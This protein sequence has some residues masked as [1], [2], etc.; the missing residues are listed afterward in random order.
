MTVKCRVCG[1]ELAN[2]WIGP[3]MKCGSLDI[4]VADDP[5]RE[6]WDQYP[7]NPYVAT[8]TSGSA[9]I[10]SDFVV[11]KYPQTWIQFKAWSDEEKKISEPL[12]K[13]DERV[14]ILYSAETERFMEKVAE[15]VA[16][17][18]NHYVMT[19]SFIFEKGTGKRI[20]FQPRP[21]E[22][23][24]QYLKRMIDDS[25]YAIILYSEQGGQIIETSWCS[26]FSKPTLGLV[27]FYRGHRKPQ[28]KERCCD[29][30]KDHGELFE[31]VCKK[32]NNYKDKTGGFICSD[33]SVFCHFTQQK[34]TKMIFDFYIT[35]P[36]MFLIGAE[37][38]KHF[39][40][41]IDNFLLG[42]MKK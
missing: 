23:L 3:C 16:A 21:K 13:K 32:E 1:Q 24:N 25:K 2:G 40:P 15:Y 34:I 39:W 37:D 41:Q 4:S 19:S 42:N 36:G 12:G 9:T 6:K 29:F 10:S 26:D 5:Y 31:C 8:L 22:A 38:W 30:L 20:A 18:R 11:N 7:I 17:K 35:N 28:E 33:P 14:V 27:D